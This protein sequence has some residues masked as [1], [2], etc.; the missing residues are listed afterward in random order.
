MGLTPFSKTTP[1]YGIR[2]SSLHF[3]LAVLAFGPC[4]GHLGLAVDR[5]LLLGLDFTQRWSCVTIGVP[6]M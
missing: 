6:G 1:F 2:H 4:S 3:P 5:L